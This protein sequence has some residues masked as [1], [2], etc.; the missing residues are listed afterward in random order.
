M[1]NIDFG[2]TVEVREN[3]LLSRHS[4]F[5]IGGPARYA[6]FPSSSQ[7]LLYTVNVCKNTNT[8]YVVIGKA[9][10]ILFD[11]MG[12]DGAVI[13]T[14]NMCSVEYIHKNGCTYVKAECG[15]SL[16]A[17]ASETGKNHSLSGLEFA[18]GIP[19]SIGGAVYMNAGAY[20]GEMSNLVVETEYLNTDTGEILTVD[21]NGHG[22]SYRHSMFADHPELIIISSTLKLIEGNPENIIALMDKNMSSRKSKQPL[23]LPNA[24]STFKRP[25]GGLFAGKLIEDCGLKGYSIGGAQISEKHAGFTVNIGGASSSDVLSLIEHTKNTVSETF[26]VVLEC[27]I[28]YVPHN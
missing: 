2:A 17:L 12:F 16:T 19:G 27:E 21:A 9:S 14:S 23:D 24:G 10:N 28:I 18:Y 3:E 20:G 26:G 4:T 1:A 5:R 15:K 22:F 7:E 25:E 8:R 13:F 6:V 11:D